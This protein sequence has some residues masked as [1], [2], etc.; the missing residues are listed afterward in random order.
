VDVHNI[1]CQYRMA[2][3][4]R[5]RFAIFDP[6]QI[7]NVISTKADVAVADEMAAWGEGKQVVDNRED[8]AQ[9][10]QDMREGMQNQGPGGMGATLVRRYTY[11][12]SCI[13]ACMLWS[14][15]SH[16]ACYT[17]PA[18]GVINVLC[19]CRRRGDGRTLRSTHMQRSQPHWAWS[20]ARKRL[21]TQ[22]YGA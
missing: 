22:I 10:L 20:G 18:E 17:L 14:S 4:L 21:T 12:E 1:S 3:W 15:H 7:S 9:E 11:L 8:D 13:H 5:G 19:W 6:D 2:R 16:N